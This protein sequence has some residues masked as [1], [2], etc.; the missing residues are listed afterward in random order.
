MCL[1]R[2]PTLGAQ[3]GLAICL[4]VSRLDTDATECRCRCDVE[5]PCLLEVKANNLP[6]LHLYRSLGFKQVG[7]RRRF[8]A[9]GGDAVLMLRQPGPVLLEPPSSAC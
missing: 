6:A 5:C 1:P 7:L 9:D 3:Q 8:Y 2:S 4:C